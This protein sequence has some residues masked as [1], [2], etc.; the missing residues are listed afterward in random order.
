MT[1]PKK[2]KIYDQHVLNILKVI[3]ATTTPETSYKTSKGNAQCYYTTPSAKEANHPHCII[4]LI[5]LGLNLPIPDSGTTTAIFN[6]WS[7][8]PATFS[9]KMRLNLEEG[10][11][12]QDQGAPWHKIID[13][14]LYNYKQPFSCIFYPTN[15]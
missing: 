14:I 15:P 3:K 7:E 13:L 8:I 1:T 6:Y 2:R 12:L 5:L 10:Q 9:E 4:A 11:R